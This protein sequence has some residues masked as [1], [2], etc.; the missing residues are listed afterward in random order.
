VTKKELIQAIVSHLQQEL[1]QMET[2]ARAAHEAATN[3]ESQAE[4][5]HD[6][7]GIEASYL[8]GAQ[9]KRAA[10][11]QKQIQLIQ[12]LPTKT[13]TAQEPISLG[14]CVELVQ[15]GRKALYFL[16]P[17]GGGIQLPW[18]SQKL[19]LI[20]SSSPLGEE[21]LGRKQGDTIEVE[22][23]NGVREYEVTAVS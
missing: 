16:I 6:T 15:D 2:A 10:D 1:T 14:A 17:Q 7:R 18:G 19:N 21:L 20:S 8:A 22:S 12:L 3:P 11:I 4:D 9:A 13:Y 5:S 23:Q